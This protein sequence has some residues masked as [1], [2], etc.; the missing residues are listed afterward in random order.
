MAW[1]GS[2]HATVGAFALGGPTTKDASLVVTLAPG[3]YSARV[4]GLNGGAGAAIIEV[5]EVP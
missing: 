2:T 4:S 5:Y 1:L 3:A